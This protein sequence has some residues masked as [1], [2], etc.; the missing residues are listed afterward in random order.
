MH[1]ST[2]E[3]GCAQRVNSVRGMNWLDQRIGIKTQKDSIQE[4]NFWI[5]GV[6]FWKDTRSC[7]ETARQV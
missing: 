6:I 1:F 4:V 2:N 5:E 7:A 3:C